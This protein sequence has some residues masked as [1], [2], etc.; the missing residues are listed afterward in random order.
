[1]APLHFDYV[2]VGAGSAGCVLANR[3]TE[4]PDTT[5]LILEAGGPDKDP[6]IHIPM[7]I[8]KLVAEQLH[9]WNYNSAPEPHADGRSI[10]HPRGKVLGG[11]S[12]INMMAYVR[13]HRRDF[14][15]WRQ[16]G[17][18][19]WS[20]ADILPYFKRSENYAG[21]GDAFHG[22]GGPLQVQESQ[23]IDPLF[24]AFLAAGDAAGHPK[25]ADFNGAEQE[26]FGTLQ[27]TI[28]A[29]R[30]SSA[31]TA[32]LHPATR[33]P[34]L[35]IV[36]GG[37]ASKILIEDG[38]A[39]GVAYLRDGKT[40]EARAKREVILSGGAVNSPQLLLLS[41]IGPGNH[42]RE[43]G[44][45]IIL[46]LPWVGR[47]LQDHPAVNTVHER[48]GLSDFHNNLRLDR[49]IR[50]FLQ[51]RLFGTGFATTVP[52][53]VTAF[54]KSAPELDL[55][56]MQLFCRLGGAAAKPWFPILSPAGPDGFAFR[57]CHLRPEARGSVTLAGPDPAAAPRIVNNFLQSEGDRR[58]L[59]EGI[60]ILRDLVRQP[61]L[62]SIAGAEL[63]PGPDVQTDAEIDAYIRQTVA[64]VYHPCA[65]AKMGDDDA[66]VVD[67]ELK[68]R[69]I[70]GLRVV[71]A[72]VMPDIVGGNLNAI[73]IMIAEKAADMIRGKAPLAAAEGV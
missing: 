41:G 7:G 57:V 68:L 44:I 29:G 23:L 62:A 22:D 18:T 30:R 34:G 42:L 16:K 59:R 48:P 17:C 37:L 27:Q 25:T 73:V 67:A 19:G 33:R 50:S 38:R 53:S 39:V 66:S 11:S 20:Y 71:D 58:V 5:V 47:N 32:F 55:S 24:S 14:D 69:G 6:L 64:T 9:N 56:D 12:S 13:G 21:A 52:S 51:A 46:D 70:D 4:D 49:L 35:T 40:L 31:A 63:E 36:T 61:T 26:G 54:L 60:K 15:R 8:G 28:G 43:H 3:L 2:I 72:S 45:D 10:Y 1:M 65:T